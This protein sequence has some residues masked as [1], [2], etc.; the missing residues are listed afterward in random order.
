ML[1][2]ILTVFALVFAVYIVYITMNDIDSCS[3]GDSTL[4]QKMLPETP[5]ALISTTLATPTESA[6]TTMAPTESTMAPTESTMAPTE[7]TMAPTM[8]PTESTMAPTESTMASESF[9]NKIKYEHFDGIASGTSYGTSGTTLD[10]S[11]APVSFTASTGPID[12]A[13]LL[14]VEG[15][16]LLSAPLADR[17]Y[18]TNSIANVN[19]NASN[20]LRGDI[21]IQY[22]TQYTPF[23]QSVIYG[24][25]MT[26]NRLT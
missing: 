21:P 22:N 17:F 4:S 26:V 24:E 8:A 3:V 25:P 19:R 2:R 12:D 5:I 20:D 23:N 18:Y 14:R 15:T 1:S 9:K 16:D 7:S 11:Y 13:D 10:D 6:M